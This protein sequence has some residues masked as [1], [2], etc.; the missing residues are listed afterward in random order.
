MWTF[1]RSHSNFLKEWASLSRCCCG[2]V[3][4]P[5][6]RPCFQFIEYIKCTLP[7]IDS[8]SASCISQCQTQPTTTYVTIAVNIIDMTFSKPTGPLLL[9]PETVLSAVYI[10]LVLMCDY[11]H[12]PAVT[13]PS[14]ST[15]ITI[16]K[17]SP[18]HH[19]FIA[20]LASPSGDTV[21]DNL[22]NG[23]SSVFVTG[24]SWTY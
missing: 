18:S 8:S 9:V 15:K 21:N 17:V 3:L 6:F 10:L 13:I 5:S 23:L 24:D 12:Y 22:P 1:S 7:A 2:C 4:P 11:R 20:L 16:E 19:N 14:G